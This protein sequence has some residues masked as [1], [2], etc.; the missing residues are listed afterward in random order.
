MESLLGTCKYNV[1][2]AKHGV[3]VLESITSDVTPTS[4]NDLTHGF[5]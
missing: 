2:Y 3:T 5:H 4:D 1:Y